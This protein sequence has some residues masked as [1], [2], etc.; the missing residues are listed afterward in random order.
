MLAVRDSTERDQLPAMSVGLW[1]QCGRMFSPSIQNREYT[2]VI[3][4]GRWP[5]AVLRRLKAVFCFQ[6]NYDRRY[7]LL[8]PY[9]QACPHGAAFNEGWSGVSGGVTKCVCVW[10]KG[11]GTR[12]EVKIVT[13]TVEKC[14][15]CNGNEGKQE[16]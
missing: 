10:R 1:S 16:I 3:K 5:L 13:D 8:H 9:P 14:K 4:P 2:A 6:Q 11:E 15:Q 12:Q 7:S